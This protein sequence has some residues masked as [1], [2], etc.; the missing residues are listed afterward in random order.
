MIQQLNKTPE[1]LTMSVHCGKK[2][3]D[4]P[5]DSNEKQ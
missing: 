4:P 2:S 1:K 3:Y 5:I